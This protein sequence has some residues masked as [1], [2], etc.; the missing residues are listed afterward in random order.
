M[1]LKVLPEPFVVGTLATV[2]MGTYFVSNKLISLL[3]DLVG[4]D[5]REFGS[6]TSIVQAIAQDRFRVGFTNSGN[7]ILMDFGETL[8]QHFFKI[9]PKA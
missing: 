7:G 9:D 3:I 1:F 6:F 2:S 4:D 5:R 8:D